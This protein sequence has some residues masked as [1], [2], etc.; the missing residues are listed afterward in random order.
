ML[1]QTQDHSS[2]AVKKRTARL[3]A[4]INWLIVTLLDLHGHYYMAQTIS[5][6]LEIDLVPSRSLVS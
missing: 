2:S 1:Y 4:R 6:A 3:S 5:M